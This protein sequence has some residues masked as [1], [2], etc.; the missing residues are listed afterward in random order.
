LDN[1]CRNDLY[2]GGKKMLVCPKC[3]FIVD[4]NDAVELFPN[5]PECNTAFNVR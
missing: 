3:G 1:G 4:R 5:C 2:Q